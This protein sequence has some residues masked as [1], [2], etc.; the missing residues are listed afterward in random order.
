MERVI[1][2]GCALARLA[3]REIKKLADWEIVSPARL[4]IVNFRF[5]P[6][7]E[8]ETKLD[9]L[10]QEISKEITASGYAQVF[11]TELRGKKVLRI[12]SINPQ[13]TEEDIVGTI[14]R[15]AHCQALGNP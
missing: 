3:E 5:A 13:T 12:C 1:N 11:T 14:Q 8:T 2:H 4:G 15:L 7:G 6:A 10:N 9:K